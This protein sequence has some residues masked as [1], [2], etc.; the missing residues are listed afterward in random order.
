MSGQIVVKHYWKAITRLQM[1]A[2]VKVA[3]GGRVPGDDWAAPLVVH[4]AMRRDANTN[5]LL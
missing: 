4:F 5:N 3:Q 1:P 2:Q